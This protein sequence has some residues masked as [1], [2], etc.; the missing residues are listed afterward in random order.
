MIGP[1]PCQRCGGHGWLPIERWWWPFTCCP[2][3]V[4]TGFDP[5]ALEYEVGEMEELLPYSLERE[6]PKCGFG[7]KKIGAAI[8]GD[9][10]KLKYVTDGRAEWFVRVCRRC[11]YQ[12][13]EMI[14]DKTPDFP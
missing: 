7:Q 6:C 3:C 8:I 5:T 4:G 10:N 14:P 11:G 1:P 12:W 2:L 9:H 13:K